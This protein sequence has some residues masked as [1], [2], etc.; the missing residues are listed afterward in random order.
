MSFLCAGAVTTSIRYIRL[1][2]CPLSAEVRAKT[3][4]GLIE[5][6]RLIP[7]GHPHLRALMSS[8]AARC[9]PPV[10][11]D[12]VKFWCE[13]PGARAED[14]ILGEVFLDGSCGRP[15]D[16]TA[17]R[18]G[19]A[20]VKLKQDGELF[21]ALWGPV[22]RRYRQSSPVVEHLAMRRLVGV[23]RAEATPVVDYAGLL[24]AYG[25][26]DPWQFRAGSPLAGLVRGAISTL[27]F[28]L[29]GVRKVKAHQDIAALVPG[30]EDWRL[31]RGNE[32]AD[33]KAKEAL[34]LHQPHDSDSMTKGQI[35][36]ERLED[37]LQFQARAMELWP[38]RPRAKRLQRGDL[39]PQAVP[40]AKEGRLQH[41]WQW[42][43]TSQIW[44][45]M[46][47]L[48]STVNKAR[49][50]DCCPGRSLKM[51]EVLEPE[52]RHVL[53]A[54]NLQPG[55]IVACSRCGAWCDR[56]PRG[57]LKHCPLTASKEGAACWERLSEGMHPKIRGCR[58]GRPVLVKS[59]GDSDGDFCF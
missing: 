9:P 52:L 58:V 51:R 48:S 14:V 23:A 41:D 39:Q 53:W 33:L 37:F 35:L 24:R 55:F 28:K 6:A 45:C 46:M 18:A 8:P 56:E 36:G 42:R 12:I 26:R 2:L 50:R 16:R 57:L 22:P 1:F 30:S 25:A 43:R 5:W 20:V 17:S 40:P 34:R 7:P 4:S 32:Q 47:R 15:W 38:R 27:G 21:A 49:R 31:A 3:D 13:D 59:L 44:V 29:A 11:E 54:F 19:W 10:D